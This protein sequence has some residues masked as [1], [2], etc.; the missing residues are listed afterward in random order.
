MKLTCV[1]P[2][3]NAHVADAG[4]AVKRRALLLSALLLTACGRRK[5]TQALALPAGSIALA[6]GDSITHGTGA[7]PEAAYPAQLARLSAW[8]VINGGVPG[9]TSAQ[10]LARLPALLSEHRPALVIVSLGG[11]DF[12]RR[13]PEADTE[14]NL[15]RCATL[16]RDADAQ[17]V[18][19]AV[20]RPTL[21][22]AI[23]A[24]LSDHPL[25]ERVATDLALPLH[26]GGWA[27]VLGDEKLRSDQIHA[28][29]EGY[30]VFAESLVTTLRAAGLLR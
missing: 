28:N 6:L 16:S 20:P 2:G 29:A 25:Y 15:R 11:N 12:L 18:L 17:V 30:R 19:V 1:K 21:A 9:D 5:A 10:A 13:L 14:A 7:A 22:A 8:S 24:G 4:A 3:P 23:G 27:R 26:A